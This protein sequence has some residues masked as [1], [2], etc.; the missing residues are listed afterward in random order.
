[1]KINQYLDATYLKTAAQANISEV[2]NQQKVLDLVDEAILYRYKLIMIRA[3]YISVTKKILSE[4][5]SKV[6]IGTVIDFPEGNSSIEN[7]LEEA[8]K[9][10]F[11]EADELDFV[12]N[13]KAFKQ[14]EI[15]LIEEEVL[16]CTKLCLDNNKVVK[17]IIEVAALSTA[18]IIVISQLI[19]EV[20]LTNFDET[21]VKK[22]F[23]KSS[24]GFFKTEQNKPNGATLE[25][26]KL[27]S[28][29]AKPLKIKAAGG[30]RDYGTAL[31]MIS[32]GV[33]RIGTSSAKE[34]CTQQESNILH[35]KPQLLI[36]IV[37]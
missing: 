13:Y 31:K 7:K 15:N 19:K 22:V 37:K 36:I 2:E 1:M 6:L 18:E 17:F 26:M 35:T 14:G 10:I 20:V 12:I 25:T 23:V 4:S 5:N 29:N 3:E 8:K 28:E 24:T 16:A 33:D 21:V 34:I 32:L 30:V 9:A 27:I 11:L